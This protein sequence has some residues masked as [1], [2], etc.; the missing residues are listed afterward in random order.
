M[1]LFFPTPKPHTPP[2]SG[3]A[4]PH[5]YGH[6]TKREFEHEVE[7]RLRRAGMNDQEV[8]IVRAA[9]EGHMD[10]NTGFLG[11]NG[12]DAHETAELIDELRHDQHHLGLEDKDV[13]RVEDTLNRSL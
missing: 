13:T 7:P 2:T 5:A 10:K 4:A 6:V 12:M 1:S 8:S 11:S 9:A 3:G